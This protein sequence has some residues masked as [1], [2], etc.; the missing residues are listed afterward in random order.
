METTKGKAAALKALKARRARN[1]KKPKI[2]NSSLPA[3]SPMFFDCLTC[4]AEI[5]VPETYL[6][7]PDLCEECLALKKLGWLE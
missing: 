3:G 4:N 1:A 6:Y 7:K 2:D 5:V